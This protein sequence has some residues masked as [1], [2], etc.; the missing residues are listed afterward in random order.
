MSG[1]TIIYFSF[2]R[3]TFLTWCFNILKYFTLIDIKIFDELNG[4]VCFSIHYFTFFFFF[5][6]LWN[7]DINYLPNWWTSCTIYIFFLNDELHR[8]MHQDKCDIF[9]ILILILIHCVCEQYN[10]IIKLSYNSQYIPLSIILR[11]R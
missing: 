6:S 5:N 3:R 1:Y 2:E 4:F 7:I 8:L 11:S 10:V 9:F